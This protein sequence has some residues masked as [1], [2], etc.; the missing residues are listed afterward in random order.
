[1]KANRAHKNLGAGKSEEVKSDRNEWASAAGSVFPW[2]LPALVGLYLKYRLMAPNSG[3]PGFRIAAQSLNRMGDFSLWEK[4]SFF[5]VD[6][7]V[8][9]LV[10]PL[11]LMVLARCLPRRFRVLIIGLLSAGVTV[12]VYTQLRALQEVGQF[13]PL[14]TFLTAAAWA[15]RE[16]GAYAEYF[17][18]KTGLAAIGIIAIAWPLRRKVKLCLNWGVKKGWTAARY[19][20]VFCFVPVLV[21][22]WL[23]RVPSSSYH[24]SALLG[25]LHAYWDEGS[26]STQEFSGLSTDELLGRYREL[27]HDSESPRD[28]LYW[29]KARGSN[30]LFFVF[31][32]LPARFLPSDDNRDDLPN[33]RRLRG[34]SFIALQHYTTFPRTHEALFS[35]LSSWYPSDVATSFEEQHPDLQAPSIMRTLSALHYHAAVY[36]PMPGWWHSYDE[37]MLRSL[38]V[39]HEIFPPDAAVLP[40]YR[41]DLLV[42][43]RKKRIARD[44]EILGLMKQDLDGCLRKRQT[45]AAVFLPQ[46]GHLPYPLAAPNGEAI[47][48]RTQSRAILKVQDGW[49]GE[50]VQL[51]EKYD[52][53]RNTVIV[54]V[55]DHGVRT[56]DE[57][58]SLV[59]GMIDEYSFH[60]PL[61]IYAPRVLDR[62]V[63]ISWLTSHIDIAPTVLDLLGVR[64]GRELEEGTPI[65]NP[66]LQKRR[67]YFFANP[68]FGADGYYS[69]GK[70]YMTN[71]MTDSVYASAQAHFDASDVVPGS[72]PLHGEV[73]LSVARM[74]GLQQVWATH[75]GKPNSLRNHLFDATR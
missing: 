16:P 49:L 33:L 66:E 47:D 50:L 22:P 18:P 52:Q 30:V 31:E 54:I 34:N 7:L 4:L 39:Q 48:L 61:L 15:W 71:H 60:V 64:D 9:L 42:A 10:I 68:M 51:L 35:L 74:A 14:R 12:A 26:V 19:V 62:P 73:S 24:T 20:G 69:N 70:F 59:G 67:T 13:L 5:R 65:W 38:G 11:L 45:F 2:I 1:M 44:I 40:E 27:A 23:P 72:S 29:G 36:R 6:V 28:S 3:S 56:R 75:F 41:E 8:D 25:A 37:Q 57:D 32:T 43:W 55:G 58:P 53:L 63:K 17:R 46:I 21:L